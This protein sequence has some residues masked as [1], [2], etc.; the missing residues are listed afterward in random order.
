MIF[1]II[2]SSSSSSSSI[3]SIIVVLCAPVLAW[4]RCTVLILIVRMHVKSI[5]WSRSRE[6]GLR[7]GNNVAVSGNSKA[8]WLCQHG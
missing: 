8:S 2:I 5:H 7:G 6:R 3:N 4:D 1:V